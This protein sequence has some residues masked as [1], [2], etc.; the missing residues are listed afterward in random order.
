MN[1]INISLTTLTFFIMMISSSSLFSFSDMKVLLD[2]TLQTEPGKMLDAN[3]VVGDIKI[4]VWDKNEAGIKIY[5]NDEAE[6]QMV[7]EASNTSGGIKV[8]GNKKNGSSLS[9]VKVHI[10]IVLPVSYDI[11][12]NTGGGAISVAGS[13]GTINYSTAGGNVKIEKTTGDI[14]GSTAGG[15][16]LITD[17]KGGIKISTAGGNVSVTGFDGNVDL[18]TA[19]GNIAMVGSNGSV[20]SSTAGGNIALDYTGENMGIDLSTAAGKII[21]D[22]PADF[23]ADA[24]ISTMVGKINC[25]FA[26]VENNMISSSI[27][28]KFN[29]G[30]KPMKCSTGAGNIT[31]RKK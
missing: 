27:N 29:N 3:M 4:T 24:D 11:K 8:E 20:K 5:G 19:G 23:N 30:G 28:T 13:N 14:N 6:S 2:K 15:N 7:F 1:K 18:S 10:E 25:D 9:G 21:V 31:I 26:S 12:L 22:L 17:T 16:V